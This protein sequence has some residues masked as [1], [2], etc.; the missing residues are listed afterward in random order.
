MSVVR[1]NEV[2]IDYTLIFS[3]SIYSAFVLL[4]LN[5]LYSKVSL[6]FS[7]LELTSSLVLSTNMIYHKETTCTIGLHH[8]YA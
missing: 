5:P 7:S 4:I 6:H 2:F 8:E 1:K 3:L